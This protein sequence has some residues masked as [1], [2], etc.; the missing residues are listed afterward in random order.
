MGLAESTNAS[1]ADTDARA[2]IADLT[3]GRRGDIYDSHG[4]GTEDGGEGGMQTQLL[5]SPPTATSAASTD[6]GGHVLEGGG[7]DGNAQA[8]AD[9]RGS[10]C[11]RPSVWACRPSAL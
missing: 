4:E 10:A 7:S 6:G 9:A 1:I 8:A 5:L 3:A 11:R 2:C